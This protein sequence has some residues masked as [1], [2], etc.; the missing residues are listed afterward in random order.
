MASTVQYSVGVCP[1]PSES[2]PSTSGLAVATHFRV[3]P[4]DEPRSK[5]GQAMG[6]TT[7]IILV[8]GV[9][10]VLAVVF[11]I[12]IRRRNARLA[13]KYGPE[14]QRLVQQA[15]PR[16][17][18][19][20]IDRRERRVE[21]FQIRS[22]SDPERS[23]YAADWQRTQARFVDDP[24]GAVGEADRLVASLMT[25]RGYPVA[26]FEQ[27]AADISV[28]HPLVVEHYRAAHDI[29]LR[30]ERSEANTEDL[31][32]ALVHYRALFSELLEERIPVEVGR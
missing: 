13:M 24:A 1:E 3:A 26:E 4:A 16:E 15:S 32:Q 19:K 28:D 21:L 27:R 17:A 30:H 10:L 12:E 5:E 31:R 22:L 11:V 23:R 6:T 8:A 25:A 14:Y 18:A 7:A 9:I 29:A 20:E 2:F